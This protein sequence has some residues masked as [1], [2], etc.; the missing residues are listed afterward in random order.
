MNTKPLVS[1]IMPCYNVER[2]LKRSVESLLATDYE[3]KE[4]ILVNDGSSDSTRQLIDNYCSMYQCIKAIHKPNGGV[5]SA[6]NAAL[7]IVAGKY[8]MFV[9][10]DDYVDTN[11]ISTAVRKAEVKQCDILLMGYS[12]PWFSNP[13][14]WRDYPP[15]E[16]YECRSNTEIIRKVFPRF[17][18]MSS[19]RLARW[20]SGDQTWQNDK[21]LPA[22]WRAMFQS[23]FIKYNGLKFRNLKMGEDS[24]FMYESMICADSL[25]TV[26]SC[27]Y[28]YEPLQQGAIV[29]TLKPENILRNKKILHCEMIRI[30]A[31]L[32]KTYG[33][34]FLDHYAGSIVIGAIQVADSICDNHPYKVW[35]EYLNSI[36]IKHASNCVS[37]SLRGG[38]LREHFLSG[39][40]KSTSTDC[41]IYY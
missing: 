36:N 24:I 32:E 30:A 40:L 27:F 11:Y 39:C 2:F 16:V 41:Y 26:Q 15:I 6:R 17:F 20:L 18:G 23:D 28:K 25:S 34:S 7:D 3:N 9:D 37:I 21:E 10:P 38:Y 4:I 8:V 31:K 14:V 29:S 1:I 5:A 13:P 22:V 19:E 12:T 33:R 35:K